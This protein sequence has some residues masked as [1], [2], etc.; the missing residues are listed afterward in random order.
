MNNF[1]KIP[2]YLPQ[3]DTASF[4]RTRRNNVDCTMIH[5]AVTFAFSKLDWHRIGQLWTN[6]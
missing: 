2:R 1:L 3:K 6:K 4:K 5:T